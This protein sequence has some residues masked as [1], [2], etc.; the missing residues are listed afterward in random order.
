MF[1]YYPILLELIRVASSKIRYSLF[2][3]MSASRKPKSVKGRIRKVRYN[4]F[5]HITSRV[6]NDHIWKPIRHVADVN[7]K[8]FLISIA[9]AIAGCGLRG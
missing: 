3:P 5:G 6:G 7:E 4:L 2:S 9:E 1:G 8:D